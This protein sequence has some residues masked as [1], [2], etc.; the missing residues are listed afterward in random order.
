MLT[1]GK[2]KTA[3]GL[4]PT[5]RIQFLHAIASADWDYSGGE[6][7]DLEE[8]VA[9]AFVEQGHAVPAP[10]DAP[11]GRP[12]LAACIRCSSPADAHAGAL[13]LCRTHLIFRM[14]GEA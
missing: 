12:A 9:R 10:A 2:R 7:V 13:L 11:L 1:L 14:R 5:R 3:G 4:A 6:V 8:P